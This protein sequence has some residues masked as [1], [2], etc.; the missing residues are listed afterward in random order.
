MQIRFTS[1]PIKARVIL[2]SPA[3]AMRCGALLSVR[4]L[5]EKAQVDDDSLRDQAAIDARKDQLREMIA[6]CASAPEIFKQWQKTEEA[7]ELAE[8]PQPA[9]RAAHSRIGSNF[10]MGRI[11]FFISFS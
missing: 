7:A 3:E 2:A 8:L 11:S 6:Q 1:Q 4:N 5:V 10:F 9:S